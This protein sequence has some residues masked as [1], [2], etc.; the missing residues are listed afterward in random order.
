[1]L[2]CKV[3]ILPISYLGL[4]LGASSKNLAVWNLVIKSTLS[5][6]FTYFMSLLPAS[7][8]ITERLECLQCNV[9]WATSEALGSIIS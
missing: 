9:L 3:D 5:N 2:N 7:D 6:I 1:M 4:P 8:K